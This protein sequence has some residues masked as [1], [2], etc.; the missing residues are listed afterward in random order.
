[1]FN[2]V[3]RPQLKKIMEKGNA[4]ALHKVGQANTKQTGDAFVNPGTPDK[5]LVSMSDRKTGK[6]SNGSSKIKNFQ[7][8]GGGK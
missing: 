3:L 4:E 1:M 7:G 6:I 8:N 2:G 5:G